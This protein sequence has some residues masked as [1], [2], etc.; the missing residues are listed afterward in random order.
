MSNEYIEQLKAK[1]HVDDETREQVI[2][3]YIDTETAGKTPRQ[4]PLA[5]V[6]GGQS[7]AGKTVLMH[8]FS[9]QTDGVQV[10]NDAM[11]ELHPQI[12]KIRREE[13]AYKKECTDQLSLSSTPFIISKLSGDN[14]TGEKFNQTIH[15]TMK[16][17]TIAK[18][19]IPELKS[20]GYVVGVAV[21]A[22]SYAES[23]QSQIERTHAQYQ[24]FGTCRHV[25]PSDHMDAINGLPPTIGFIEDNNIADFIFVYTRNYENIAEP[26]LQHVYLNPNTLQTTIPVLQE[27]GLQ[28][29]DF[30]NTFES[31]QSAIIKLRELDEAR[32]METLGDRIDAVIEDGGYNVPGMGEHLQEIIDY[33]K[34]YA[35]SHQSPAEPFPPTEN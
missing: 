31:A 32:C 9:T 16:N 5:V 3:Q 30:Q 7:G 1:Y 23:K 28:N 13:P 24:S 10:D 4:T 14:P 18:M 15:Q 35:I 20:K 8:K 26:I 19:A 6:V 12:E 22:V 2:Q 33:S 27:Y 29:E 34:Q 21:L 11:R 17:T 25:A